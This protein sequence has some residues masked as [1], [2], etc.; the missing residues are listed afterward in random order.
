MIMITNS[1]DTDTFNGYNKH[2]CWDNYDFDRNLNGDMNK[3]IINEHN[4]K[5]QAS[6]VANVFTMGLHVTISSY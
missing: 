3:N 1:N 4:T 6:K 2:H 5:P